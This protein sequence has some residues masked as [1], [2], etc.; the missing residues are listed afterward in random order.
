MKN[1]S[2]KASGRELIVG[3]GSALI[4]I[5]IHEDD[6]F[7]A[8]TGAAKAG[9]TLVDKEM[10]EDTL[11]NS[12]DTPRFVP[13]GSACNTVIGVGNLGGHARFVGKCGKGNNAQ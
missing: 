10:I 5:L 12:S 9:M 11:E 7:L 4:D 3:I 13:G 8:E 1:L 6:Q 2:N